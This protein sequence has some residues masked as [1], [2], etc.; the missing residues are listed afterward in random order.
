MAG[1]VACMCGKYAYVD[2]CSVHRAL[3][4]DVTGD[5]FQP[6]LTGTSFTKGKS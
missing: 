6:C 1:G 3:A 2:W 4:P 5:G